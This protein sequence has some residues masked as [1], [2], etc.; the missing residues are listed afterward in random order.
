[1]VLWLKNPTAAV[2]VTMEV[3]VQSPGP[4]NGLKGFGTAAAAV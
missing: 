4:H 2:Q 1:M 3:Q